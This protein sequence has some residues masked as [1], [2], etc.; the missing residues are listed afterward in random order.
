LQDFKPFDQNVDSPD[1]RVGDSGTGTWINPW[2][3]VNSNPLTWKITSG[4]KGGSLYTIMT[5]DDGDEM[6]A[7][8]NDDSL[9][10]SQGDAYA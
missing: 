4:Q 9:V 3:K 7:D 8:S 5:T 2:F 10:A 6:N 1:Y